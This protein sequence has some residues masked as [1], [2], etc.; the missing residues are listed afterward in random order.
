MINASLE[1]AQM[2]ML[3]PYGHARARP[4]DV[5]IVIGALRPKGHEV[6]QR[7]GDGLYATLPLPDFAGE[8][9]AGA[10]LPRVGQGA[11]RRGH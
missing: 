2:R 11:R 5:L 7:L 6:A 4:V 3:H 1:G 10:A 9:P 8:Y